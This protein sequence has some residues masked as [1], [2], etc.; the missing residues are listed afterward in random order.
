MTERQDRSKISR[1]TVLKRAGAATAALALPYIVPE[2]IGRAKAQSS[3]GTIRMMGGPTVALED[4]AQFEKDTGL[5]MEFVPFNVDD[6]G[7][8][9][10]EILINGAGER[11]DLINTLAGVQKPLV[12][13]GQVAQLDT[14]KLQNYAGI[15]DSVKRS[16]V[17]YTGDDKDW[18]VPLYYNADSFGY[19]PEKLGLPRP[20]E[21]LTWD[22]LLNSEE[23]LGKAALDGDMIALMI[24]GMYLKSRGLADIADPGNMTADEVALATDWLIERKKAGQFRTLWKTYDEQVA[25]FV[26]GEVLVQRC[27]EPAVKAVQAQGLDVEYAT[28]SDF[29][30]NWMHSTFIPVQAAERNNLDEIYRALDWFLGGSYAAELAVLRG[31]TGSRMDLGLEHARSEGWPDEKIEAIEANIVKVETKFSNPNFWIGGAPDDLA[32]HDREMARF[33]NA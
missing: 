27:W 2:G 25:N 11:F 29:H 24:G 14:S 6:V 28:C 31:Y 12:Q 4:W 8:L 1:R 7:A 5:K 21:A 13:Q 32:A 19:F 10:N 15:A 22:L 33:R 20:P 16:P 9:Y 30:V 17:L 3:P 18:C 23:T 26:N